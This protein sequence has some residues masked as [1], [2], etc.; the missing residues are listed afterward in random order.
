MTADFNT[1]YTNMTD[2][3]LQTVISVATAILEKRQA[4][5]A[6]ECWGRLKAIFNEYIT[7]YGD[8]ALSSWNADLFLNKSVCLDKV[9]EIHQ[10][11]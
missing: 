9:G 1:N 10:D 6:Q 5:A 4:I 2:A 7:N 11:D 3:E 8:I